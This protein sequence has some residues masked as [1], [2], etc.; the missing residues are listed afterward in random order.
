MKCR[1]LYIV[2]FLSEFLAGYSQSFG[3]YTSGSAVYCDSVNSG[4][5]SL[6]SFSGTVVHW[7]Y[8]INN[9]N[10]WVQILNPTST[11][12]YNNLK[13]TTAYRAIVQDGSFPPDTS[14][15]ATITIHVPGQSGFISGGG[16]FCGTA[17]GTL[18]LSVTSG[19]VLFWQSSENNGNSWQQISQ[20]QFTLP[21]TAI[22]KSTF[23]R[24][25]VETFAGCDAD[26]SEIETVS[27]DPLSAAGQI[28]GADSVCFNASG[29]TLFVNGITGNHLGWL[30]SS[31]EGKSWLN[32]GITQ[33]FFIYP[34]V[35]TT[36][37]YAVTA[38]SGSCP[39]DTG[40][41]AIVGVYPGTPASAGADRTITRY[42][43]V[44][45][46]GS[47]AG[48]PLWNNSTVLS[49]DSIFDPVAEPHN[50][51]VFV[52]TV[53]DRNNC[54]SSDSVLITVL[55]PI[56]TAIT[57]NGDGINDRFEIDKIHLY[58]N[59]TLKIFDRWGAVQYEA[60][61][62]NNDWEGRNKQGE[63]LP[64][65]FYYFAFDYGN[66]EKPATGYILI[67]KH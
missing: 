56:P 44:Q 29:D 31:D 59:N 47:G 10:N 16:T 39:P 17:N 43:S 49:N 53:T 67:K 51:T 4:F 20:T 58:Q 21:F 1:F 64:D 63:E 46:E 23:Y 27:V 30:I 22:T 28:S 26:T 55:V 6:N 36:S 11:Q 57:P 24:A 9:G 48:R 52:L 65:G 8:S 66:G 19:T 34:Q 37:W 62:Y 54:T 35:Q 18:S 25:I 12:S 42:E 32:S 15:I 50:T 45:L 13:V 2:V 40:N 41:I 5:I 38:Q 33:N 3:G 61:P 60:A 14:S 7:E